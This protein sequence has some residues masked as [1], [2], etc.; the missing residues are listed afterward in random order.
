MA[1]QV[2]IKSD[3]LDW[4]K[5]DDYLLAEVESAYLPRIG[6]EFQYRIK[7]GMCNEN[8]S[9]VVTNVI[10]IAGAT[11]SSSPIPEKYS[12]WSGA[13]V[14]VEPISDDATRARIQ[15]LQRKEG[16]YL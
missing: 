6:D 11:Y 5:R 9:F 1:F 13:K 8:F 14:I 3:K 15:L 12:T 7:A 10:H 4:E 2:I 16:L